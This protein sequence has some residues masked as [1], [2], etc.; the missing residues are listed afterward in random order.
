MA[1]ISTLPAMAP[2]SPWTEA[3]LIQAAK[4]TISA[5]DTNVVR[6][7]IIFQDGDIL[8]VYGPPGGPGMLDRI[9]IRDDVPCA[10]CSLKLDELTPGAMKALSHPSLDAFVEA[11]GKEDSILGDVE[12]MEFGGHPPRSTLDVSITFEGD[13]F[14]SSAPVTT[15]DERPHSP[16][17]K[18]D[19]THHSASCRSR[20]DSHGEPS[21]DSFMSTS[22]EDSD[23][24]AYSAGVLVVQESE[25]DADKPTLDWKYVSVLRSRELFTEELPE[26]PICPTSVFIIPQS[27]YNSCRWFDEIKDRSICSGTLS[28]D[29]ETSRLNV[30][31][32]PSTD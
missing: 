1:S 14:V 24:F 29:P 20:A 26:T 31:F 11:A 16:M 25:P 3:A 28:I 27:L 2:P 5:L 10:S 8:R 30:E 4:A 12:R 6:Y 13:H 9:D 7:N 19:L 17:V 18:Q 23:G 22:S 15:G 32:T 21:S